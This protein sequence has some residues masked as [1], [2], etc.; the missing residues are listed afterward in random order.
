VGGGGTQPSKEAQ[1]SN[2][3]PDHWVFS[4]V[5]KVGGDRSWYNGA[6]RRWRWCCSAGSGEEER[7]GGKGCRP[8][9]PARW[10]GLEGH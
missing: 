2:E 7:E 6:R 1:L 4:V 9:G 8:G 3:G 10:D 5:R